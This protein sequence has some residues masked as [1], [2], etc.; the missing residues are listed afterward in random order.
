ME[1]DEQLDRA[2]ASLDNIEENLKRFSNQMQKD[3][4][5]MQ[6]LL[7]QICENIKKVD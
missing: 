6:K 7:N 4:A 3:Y 2:K 1:I 5:L